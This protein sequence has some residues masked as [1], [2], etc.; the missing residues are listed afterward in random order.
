MRKSEYLEKLKD[1]N[2]NH[3]N[4]IRILIKTLDYKIERLKQSK[5]ITDDICNK[6]EINCYNY[7]LVYEMNES[8][9]KFINDLDEL[10]KKINDITSRNS[11]NIDYDIQKISSINDL[12]YTYEVQL[13]NINKNDLSDIEKLQLN[14]I[15]KEIYE[16]F[17][18]I[19]C[20]IDRDILKQKYD[21]LQNRNVIL[22]ALDNFFVISDRVNM[23]RENLFKAIKGIDDYKNS[24]VEKSEPAREYKIIYILADIELYLSQNRSDKNHQEQIQKIID[25]KDKINSVFSIDKKELKKSISESNKSRLPMVLSKN[26]GK[27]KRKQKKIIEFLYKNGYTKSIEAK[28]YKSKMDILIKKLKLLSDNVE[29]EINR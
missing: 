10:I 21:K 29:R 4:N 6:F 15:K 5:K 20:E 23:Q 2:K 19:K 8:R 18:R 7:N 25:I 12:L 1:E 3:I 28:Q 24:L 9:V 22:K 16:K 17:M 11:R 26:I 14:A 13:N 27:M